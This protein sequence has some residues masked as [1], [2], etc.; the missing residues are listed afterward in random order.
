M[1]DSQTISV[2]TTA[3][4]TLCFTNV[5]CPFPSGTQTCDIQAFNIHL[6]GT[7]TNCVFYSLF[8]CLLQPSNIFSLTLFGHDILASF[9]PA[10]NNLSFLYANL[11][12]LPNLGADKR[13]DAVNFVRKIRAKNI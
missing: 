3:I 6:L 1:T 9:P 5:Q 4:L 11:A 13:D 10:G 12:I 7:Q 2:L 8:V